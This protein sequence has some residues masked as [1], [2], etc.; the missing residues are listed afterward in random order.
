[1]SRLAG[2]DA[3]GVSHPVVGRDIEQGTPVCPA[4]VKLGLRYEQTQQGSSC[5]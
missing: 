2:L 4:F 1:M 3:P 5:L